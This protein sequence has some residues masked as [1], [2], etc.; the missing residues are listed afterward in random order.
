MRT[1]EFNKVSLFLNGTKVGISFLSFYELPAKQS[2]QDREAAVPHPA[3]TYRATYSTSMIICYCMGTRV[4]YQGPAD[5]SSHKHQGV[6]PEV[7]QNI[8]SAL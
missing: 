4:P 5:P 1:E 6:Q 3:L 2:H 8:M 7:T